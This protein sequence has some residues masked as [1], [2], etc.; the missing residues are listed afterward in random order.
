VV[1]FTGG[2]NPVELLSSAGGEL[3]SF[4]SRLCAKRHFILAFGGVC[5]RFDPGAAAEFADGH[6]KSAIGVL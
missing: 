6:T 2:N 4:S 1:R 3:Q 5:Q